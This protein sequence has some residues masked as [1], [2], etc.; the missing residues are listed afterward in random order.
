MRELMKQLPRNVRTGHDRVNVY[1]ADDMP[2][3]EDDAYRTTPPPV[4]VIWECQYDDDPSL[5]GEFEDDSSFGASGEDLLLRGDTCFSAH[6]TFADDQ[7][8]CEYDGEH[9][10]EHYRNSGPDQSDGAT[11]ATWMSRLWISQFFSNLMRTGSLT[12]ASVLIGVVLAVA[13]SWV[14]VPERQPA[15]AL[16]A[17]ISE[18]PS[19]DLQ[20]LS[21]ATKQTMD[22][23]ARHRRA[24]ADMKY[25][26]Y[27]SIEGGV[28]FTPRS[29]S[30]FDGSYDLLIHFH[31]NVNVVVESAVAAKLNA[32]IAVVNLGVGSAHYENY[33]ACPGVYERFLDNIQA[34]MKRR[35]LATPRLRRVAL[36]AWSAG[37]GAISTI[38][39][40]RKG[41]DP[42][43]AL[44]VMDGIHTGYE[45]GRPGVLESRKLAPFEDAALA[46]AS[47]DLLFSI[48]YSEIDPPGYAGSRETAQ[49]L[50]QACTSRGTVEDEPLEV[51]LYRKLDAMRGAIA[52]E[53]VQRL[54]PTTNRHVG[55]FHVRGYEGNTRGHHM[56]HL[57]QMGATILPE[58]VTRWQS[59]VGYAGRKNSLRSVR[60]RSRSV[61]TANAVP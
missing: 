38:L 2:F 1:V 31:G 8:L 12:W 24:D 21:G 4:S 23:M 39:K 14:Q 50:L 59:Y 28:L 18:L 19:F 10:A 53:D 42:L 49:Y 30:S 5:F 52:K 6:H 47:G 45:P 43:D 46:A 9:C 51:P 48:T 44:L 60:M 17:W 25:D 20:T 29:F 3:D 56:A 34:G 35:G 54:S 13:A 26:G 11:N 33:F 7:H 40:Q 55:Q 61:S 36:S 41:L 16:R 58:L 37:Y 15:L 32:A 57:F 22:N 27:A